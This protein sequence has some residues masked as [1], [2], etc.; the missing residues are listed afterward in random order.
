MGYTVIL[1][2]IARVKNIIS[3][4]RLDIPVVLI[5]LQVSI[6]AVDF[7]RNTSIVVDTSLP[8]EINAYAHHRPLLTAGNN[9]T[10]FEKLFQI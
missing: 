3:T 4:F 8:Q 2:F 9:S 1:H 7:L 10:V 6:N 5:G